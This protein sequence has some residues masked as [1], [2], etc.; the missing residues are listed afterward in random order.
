MDQDRLIGLWRE[1]HEKV[2]PA[3]KTLLPLIQVFF[4]APSD[5]TT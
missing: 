1:H 4:L 3:G 5:I 2:A